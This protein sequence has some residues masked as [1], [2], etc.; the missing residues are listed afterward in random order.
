MHA[1]TKCYNPGTKIS[2][3]PS[4]SCTRWL[5]TISTETVGLAKRMLWCVPTIARATAPHS[6]C[7]AGSSASQY[8][9]GLSW[10]RPPPRANREASEAECR[11]RCYPQRWAAG[12]W[13]SHWSPGTSAAWGH[14]SG[15]P[16]GAADSLLRKVGPSVLRWTVNSS[17]EI[18]SF[19]F[20]SSPWSCTL[21]S[22][23]RSPVPLWVVH[24]DII[25]FRFLM[26]SQG[27]LECP[28]GVLSSLGVP[29]AVEIPAASLGVPGVP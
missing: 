6:G 21:P 18:P 4:A 9:S 29:G 27:S 12:W 17:L 8:G 10:L 5:P 24:A 26:G 28:W 1:Y 14:P 2:T 16:L 25:S 7:K 19:T 11:P 23:T 3:S 13:Y 20:A 15:R 22:S